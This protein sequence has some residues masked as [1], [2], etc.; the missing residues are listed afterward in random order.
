MQTTAFLGTAHIHTPGFISTIQKRGDVR[1]K[2]VYDHDNARAQKDAQQLNA[3]V[4]DI[5]TILADPEVTSG[6]DLL[7]NAPSP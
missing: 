3:Q 7:G 5:A 2:Y 1:V 6:C 4:A